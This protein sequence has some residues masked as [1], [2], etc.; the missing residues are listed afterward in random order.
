MLR[1]GD[2]S[3]GNHRLLNRQFSSRGLLTSL[4]YGERVDLSV[5]AMNGTR[6]VG[7]RNPLGL[8]E[9]DH[10][11][12]SG[13]LGIEFLKK[14]PGAF[15]LEGSV[16][17]GSVLPLTNFNQGGI[18]DAEKSRG[19]GLRLLAGTQRFR[20]EA[21]YAGSRYTNP[22]DPNLAL[23][24]DLVPVREETRYAHYAQVSA[25]ILQNAPLARNLPVSLQAVYRRERVDPLYR[26]VAAYVQSDNLHNV[27]E[28]QGSLAAVSFQLSHSR[29]EDNL[30]EIPSIL[31]TL[32]RQHSAFVGV[33]LRTLAR[34]SVLLPVIS[35][36]FNRTHQFGDALPENGGFSPS[37]VPDQMNRIHNLDLSWQGIRWVVSSRFSS[38]FQDN[39]QPDRE[40]ADF[41]NQSGSL[42]L[43][44][45]PSLRLSLGLDV[46]LDRTKNRAEDRIDYT[47][48]IGF[49]GSLRPVDP[50][51]FSG[52]VAPTLTRN[53]ANTTRSTNIN[54]SFE[55]AW[56]FQLG[57]RLLWP[58]RG[59]VFVR[60]A[61]QALRYTDTLF[62]IHSENR[63]WSL[64]TGVTLTLF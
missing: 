3:H 34:G 35:Y 38:A 28:L 64:D 5:A 50:I 12:V 32:T 20:L 51:L 39:R 52:T 19:G 62:A 61:R 29:T 33:P 60:Y 1:A 15:R 49:R 46:S 42:G 13:S 23:G 54:Y 55:G 17:N 27:F 59:Q 9:P 16:L 26:T 10:R 25:G 63:V 45:D 31:K 6:V 24:D 22:F 40:N 2:V 47:R 48:R 57:S 41:L 30:D 58:A 21:G 53:D 7:W 43:N 56:S 36:G 44:F 14:R 37:H 18:P 11:I 4:T 8:N